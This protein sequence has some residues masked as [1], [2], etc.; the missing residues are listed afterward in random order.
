[1]EYDIDGGGYHHRVRAIVPV[2]IS[3]RERA[4]SIH[5]D[6]DARPLH[7][8]ILNKE[9]LITTLRALF[10]AIALCSVIIALTGCATYEHRDGGGF[11]VRYAS[12]DMD[13]TQAAPKPKPKRVVRKAAP[14]T[15]THTVVMIERERGE[16]HPVL[17]LGADNE[18]PREYSHY[19]SDRSLRGL[20]S[21]K[22]MCK[23]ARAGYCN[24]PN[25][26]HCHGPFCHAHPGGDR[27]HTH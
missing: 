4:A 24:A 15:E 9:Q 2:H 13:G 19:V 27:R 26:P 21:R 5:R 14:I 16:S 10:V 3:A 18:I 17:N 11:T 7:P 25:V 6:E 8:A 22:A 12:A 23:D 1:M 20:R